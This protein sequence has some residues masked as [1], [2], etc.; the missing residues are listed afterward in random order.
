V[1]VTAPEDSAQQNFLHVVQVGDLD[2]AEMDAA[3]RIDG[4]GTVGARIDAGE[5]TIEVRFATEGD[6]AGE[7]RITRGEEVL[8]D[9]PLTTRIQPQEGLATPQD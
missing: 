2:L 9:R 8:V 3:E 6:L 7:V 4:E 5:R 1:E